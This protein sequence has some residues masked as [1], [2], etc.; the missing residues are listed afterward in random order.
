PTSTPT[1]TQTST[2]SPT[3]TSSP[4]PSKDPDKPP[5]G[6]S[7]VSSASQGK[8]ALAWARNQVGKKYVYGAAGPN[9]VDCSGLTMRSWQNGGSVSLM[10]SSRDQYRTV[11]KIAYSDLRPGDLVFWG[12]NPNDPNSVYHVALYAG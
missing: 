3:K 1:P 7:S 4:K 9:T 6:G 2:P 12:N 10:R 11:K 5:P 8:A